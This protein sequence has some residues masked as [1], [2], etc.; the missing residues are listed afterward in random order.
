MPDSRPLRESLSGRSSEG[1]LQL[2]VGTD[3]LPVRLCCPGAP[4]RNTNRLHQQS[5]ALNDKVFGRPKD[6]NFMPPTCSARQIRQ[7]PLVYLPNTPRYCFFYGSGSR[8][9]ND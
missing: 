6:P 1:I 3:H 4:G 8:T 5:S 7:V 9:I 2:H